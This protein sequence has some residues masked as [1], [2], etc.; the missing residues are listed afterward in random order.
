MAMSPRINLMAPA[1]VLAWRQQLGL[2]QTEA[3]DLLGISRRNYIKLEQGD[4]PVYKALVLSM[5]MIREIAPE[6][7]TYMEIKGWLEDYITTMQQG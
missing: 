5:W 7:S 2:H 1:Q 3:A 6:G 4:S